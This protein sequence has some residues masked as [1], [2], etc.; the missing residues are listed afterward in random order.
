MSHHNLQSQCILNDGES[1]ESLLEP[2]RLDYAPDVA[3]EW[4]RWRRTF[5]NFLSECSQNVPQ[6]G[7]QPNKLRTLTNYASHSVFKHLDEIDDYD[8]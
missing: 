1:L 6:G 8:Q 3:K 4:K 5:E 7:H 2:T